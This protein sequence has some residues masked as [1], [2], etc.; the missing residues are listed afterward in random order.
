MD[1]A[2]HYK[3][4]PS[5]ARPLTP[6]ATEHTT[7]RQPSQGKLRQAKTR[8]DSRLPSSMMLKV[9]TIAKENGAKEKLN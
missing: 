1:E 5:H 3:G 9:N 7:S 4:R 2:A 6:A 8:Q